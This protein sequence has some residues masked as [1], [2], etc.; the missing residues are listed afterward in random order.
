M[1]IKN[2]FNK[3][4]TSK[5]LRET[6]LG[7][8]D[9]GYLQ[10]NFENDNKFV[11]YVDYSNPHNFVFYGLAEQYYDDAFTRISKTYPYDGSTRERKLWSLSSSNFDLY[12]L[13][14]L[15]PR[16]NGH[17]QLGT[18]WSTNSNASFNSKQYAEATSPEYINI[19]KQ[20]NTGSYRDGG[21]TDLSTGF[22]GS[23]FYKVSKDRDS[24]L[25]F[26]L[27]NGATVE[28]WFKHGGQIQSSTE[29]IFDL[30]NGQETGSHAAP[31][32]DYG[33]FTIET[34]GSIS[35]TVNLL[36][37]AQSGTSGIFQQSVGEVTDVTDWKH[38]AVRLK[39]DNS[40]IKTELFVNGELNAASTAGTSIENVTGSL[41][42]TIGA[43]RTAP[44]GSLTVSSSWGSVS[45]SFDEFRYWKTHRTH[46]DIGRFYFTHVEAGTN[47]D[48]AE[49]E[50][51][52]YYKFNEGITQTG[53]I[54]SIVLDYSGRTTNGDW[55][56]YVSGSR[57]TSSAIVESSTAESEFLDPII[58]DF[59]PTVA[60]EKA[61]YVNSGSS[62]DIVNNSALYNSVPS[63]V[64]DEDRGEW[65][66]LSQIVGS[67][68]DDLH[69]LIKEVPKLRNI[70]YPSG[71]D[72]PYTIASELMSHVGIEP[73]D[74]FNN[75]NSLESLYN[76]DED[77]DFEARLTDIK[78]TIFINLYNNVVDLYKQ[79]GTISAL[80]NVFHCFGIDEK[81]ISVNV[82][83][84]NDVYEIRKNFVPRSVKKKYAD[85]NNIDR[86]GSS[87]YQQ[88][89][90]AHPESLGYISGSGLSNSEVNLPITME[91]EVIFPKKP[92]STLSSW[93]SAS[94]T[95]ITSSIFGCH[96]AI[97][98]SD[99][100]E[101]TW[102]TGSIA[103]M[104]VYAVR[105]QKRSENVY[106]ECKSSTANTPLPTLTSSLFEEVYDNQKWNVAVKVYPTKRENAGI[107]S[108]STSGSNTYTVEFQGVSTIMG[109]TVNEFN[110]T[111]TMSYDKG[112]D[113][114]SAPKR[115]YI[116]AH[117]Q[118]FTGSVLEYSDVKVGS[119]RYWNTYLENETVKTHNIDV[120]NY[121]N[122]R[123]YIDK[124][125]TVG[126]LGFKE[127]N[128][129]ELLA[130]N[131]EF[132]T[133]TGSDSSGQFVVEDI[134]SGSSEFSN[135]YDWVGSIVGQQYTG[136]GYNFPSSNTEVVD[137]VYLDSGK[138][139]PVEQLT[140]QD[141][142]QIYESDR[143]EQIQ[144]ARPIKYVISL[145][146][147]MYRNISDEMIEWL[148]NI[149]E[150]DNL[151]GEP[152]HAYHLTYKSLEQ[153]RQL[154]FE[155]VDNTP[156]FERF[157]EM[158]KWIDNSMS[159]V[160]AQFIPA[161]GRS[162]KKIR[163]VIESH[164]LERPKVWRK[165]PTLEFEVPEPEADLYGINRL[166]YPWK[167]GHHPVSGEESDNC[168]Y[169]KNR[170]LR[171]DFSSG[172]DDVDF[173]REQY[174]SASLETRERGYTTPYRAIIE[175]DI[176]KPE[177]RI[178]DFFKGANI[179]SSD[180]KYIWSTQFNGL[181][182]CDDVLNPLAKKKYS[183]KVE[184]GDDTSNEYEGSLVFPMPLISASISGGLSDYIIDKIGLSVEFGSKMHNELYADFTQNPVQSPWTNHAVG[185][186]KTHHQGVNYNL[187]NVSA[188]IENKYIILEPDNKKIAAYD[189]AT[190]NIE[191][192]S[193]GASDINT[194]DWP[195][196][197]LRRDFVA[198][199]ILNLKNI[200]HT[201]S[202]PTVIGNYDKK[203]QYAQ[204]GS[205]FYNNMWFRDQTGSVQ[206]T[207]ETFLREKLNFELP[208]RGRNET[209]IVPV[210][211]A[212]G[213]HRT[214]TRG[215]RDPES[216]VK[217]IY[218]TLNYRN[219]D[220]RKCLDNIVAG[221]EDTPICDANWVNDLATN[222][223]TTFGNT[224]TLVETSQYYSTEQVQHGC[225]IPDSDD[226]AIINGESGADHGINRIT[227][228]GGGTPVW[229]SEPV[230]NMYAGAN[231]Q[232]NLISTDD[233]VFSSFRVG[234]SYYI[235][236]SA[237]ADG[238]EDW[239]YSYGVG[240][241]L[242]AAD[243]SG[244]IYAYYGTSL[245]VFDGA[246][247]SAPSHVTHTGFAGQPRGCAVTGDSAW[248][249]TMDSTG[250][251]DFREIASKP[252]SG[253]WGADST[254]DLTSVPTTPWGPPDSDS[255]IVGCPIDTTAVWV[256]EDD[257]DY[258]YK[259]DK[260][261]NELA[262]IDPGDDLSGFGV[263]TVSY[264]GIAVDQYG[265]LY[266][267]CQYSTTNIFICKYDSNGTLITTTFG[268]SITISTT[269]S[270]QI[271]AL[272]C[273]ESAG[274]LWILR[275]S[276]RVTELSV[277]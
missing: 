81:L 255:M 2:L 9:D 212:P 79:K 105:D 69:L 158:Y 107:S 148:G 97:T 180:R 254:V 214:L 137:N 65:K 232:T 249:V 150:F 49:T 200:Q 114:L 130:L 273:G 102:Q 51:G 22:S 70:Q 198:K 161:S 135:R 108:G 68:F 231:T 197:R 39:N 206:S 176:L 240:N 125:K 78:N 46:Q 188:R 1:A 19:S 195:K 56:N 178:Y 43:F 162:D 53:S 59:H 64:L 5:D 63:W 202:S 136:L 123:S 166:L 101:T 41:A 3:A 82:Y 205:R 237:L 173:N 220:A 21:M 247:V 211:S 120:E 71:S 10:A 142:I 58:W 140:S 235:A 138:Y 33:R 32:T 42:A 239:F 172:D 104:Q 25:E 83:G 24:N 131:W 236:R 85:F 274:T 67:Y 139:G 133:V 171:R 179:D 87:I 95:H 181:K 90:S 151:I 193:A 119:L 168:F 234:G 112:V 17:I 153:L 141:M 48:D 80:R 99:I 38:Y 109:S 244:I 96:T 50:L 170:A 257:E 268:Q 169:W 155:H 143:I 160:V 213:D 52:V 258:I 23:N 263:S 7:Y 177:N 110:V 222:V 20:M 144:D 146:K 88:T 242:L 91:A 62:Y 74:L 36:V 167:F 55:V 230:N 4:L 66:R 164:I 165:W 128:D 147:S 57:L 199:S 251:L 248:L 174:L 190:E 224:W 264:K 116:G 26:D 227:T 186:Y 134:T 75:I 196:E 124:Y 256:M 111:G 61:L 261:G 28:F 241:A 192:D 118:D 31:N 252:G 30:W 233:G 94:F 117:R 103:D 275:D 271:Q 223:P 127:V 149:K 183:F 262:K 27:N 157:L 266:V 238:N 89:S 219:L 40:N 106:F 84:D 194:L 245:D 208:D 11:P 126:T 154:F 15:Y 122:N 225:P 8:E 272:V 35:G 277:S 269:V 253:A 184:S 246:S 100:D 259:F 175:K 37:T 210:F 250:D 207:P 163:T 44:S 182:D 86:F 201:S 203:Y 228:S 185:G 156:D 115:F 243:S 218:A 121:G 12:V 29:V 93:A 77:R 216:E 16:T 18:G 13:E 34:T 60:T 189:V 217:S 276:G 6:T 265:Y 204:V 209:A 270:T 159:T 129:S 92:D 73:I 226:C 132:D 98:G 215:Y 229:F 113:F 14:N 47:E 152:I 72:K 191:N 145:E 76:R 45:G 54:D 187:D 267:G 221:L 260:D